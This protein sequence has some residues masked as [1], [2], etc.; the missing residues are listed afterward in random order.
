[1]SVNIQ[2]FFLILTINRILQI[3]IKKQLLSILLIYLLIGCSK[4]DIVESNDENLLKKLDSIQ[5]IIKT[6]ERDKKNDQIHE[7]YFIATSIDND[8]IRC[9][10]LLKISNIVVLSSDTTFFKIVNK[11]VLNI[12]NEIKNEL[13]I[14]ESFWNYAIYFINQEKHSEAYYHYHQAYLI[15]DK[16]NKD[17]YK[18]RMLNN[19]SFILSRFKDYQGSEKL[20]FEAITVF[21]E[22]DKDLNLYQCYKRLG[23]MYNELDEYEK[24]L[25]FHKKSFEY[26]KNTNQLLEREPGYLNNLSLVYQ[27]MGDHERAISLLNEILD[28]KLVD[29]PNS[30]LLPKII[31]NRA[32]NRFLSGDISDVLSDFQRALELR[33]V[34]SDKS[35]QIISYLHLAEYYLFIENMAN[36]LEYSRKALE[37]SENISNNRDILNSLKLMAKIDQKN[38]HY[39]WLKYDQLNDSILKLERTQRDKITRIRFQTDEITERAEKLSIKNTWIIAFSL[40]AICIIVLLFYISSQYSKHKELILKSERQEAINEISKLMLDRNNELVKGKMIERHRIAEELHDG[41]LGKLFG[42]RIGLGFLDVRENSKIK[43]DDYIGEIQNAENDIRIIS[44]ELKYELLEEDQDF[45]SLLDSLLEKQSRITKFK[46]RIVS[47]QSID[48]DAVSNYFKINI[49][50]I[51]QEALNNINKYSR[52]SFVEIFL[53]KESEILKIKIVDNGTGF[54]KDQSTEGIGLK[55]IKSRISSFNGKFQVRS[56]QEVGTSLL[57]EI[58]LNDIIKNGEL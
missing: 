6:F 28:K 21:E 39:Y 15:Y 8:S 50:R 34:Q 29:A 53:L 38:S 17:Y 55:N 56:K 42:A 44:H 27:K 14:A 18:A 32:Y 11:E 3:I 41:V 10:E 43:F 1:M 23:L 40:S 30:L 45:I 47:S 22:Y 54:N 51:I 37:I 31:D 58:K 36:A 57:I 13:I 49:Y 9:S 24:S 19:M 48:W 12:A 33:K 16:L 2:G 5:A 7:A 26:L 35:G 46:F 52:A 4:I 20:I 25:D